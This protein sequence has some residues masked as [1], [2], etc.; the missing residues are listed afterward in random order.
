[1]TRTMPQKQY[2]QRST[3]VTVYKLDGKWVETINELIALARTSHV[4][5]HRRMEE[6][7]LRDGRRISKHRI[8]QEDYNKIFGGQE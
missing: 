8:S 3:T 6:G 5:V 4:T 1:M 7:M 2:Y